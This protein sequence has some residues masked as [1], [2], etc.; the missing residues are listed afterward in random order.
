[1]FKGMVAVD[2]DINAII[3]QY[4]AFD[5]PIPYKGLLIDPVKARDYYK[6]MPSLGV[7]N[8][9]KN[10]IPDV[11]I[12]QMSYLQFVFGL[13]LNDISWREKFIEVM[14]LCLDV[15]QAE[16]ENDR[17]R[18][19]S[20]WNELGVDEKLIFH[21]N[22]YDIDFIDNDNKLSIVIKGHELD[23]SEFDTLIKYIHY[24]NLYDYFDDFMS[25]DVREIVEKFYAMK[26]KGI[27]PPTFEEKILAVMVELGITKSQVA[28]MSAISV[29]QLFHIAVRKTDY[30]VEH[31]YRANAIT[32]KKLPDVEHWAYKTN[33]ERFSEVFVDAQS[34][35]K[36]AQSV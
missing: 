8:I 5:E 36:N 17:I 24:Q 31:N 15:K 13:I 1:M 28:D 30:V 25:D 20:F 9:Q 19:G 14:N 16:C 26:N 2:S 4:R 32:D 6:F 18:R 29:E 33:K 34:F 22:G 10:R 12:I 27:K 21:L 3:E 11:Q 35:T 23:A 7:L